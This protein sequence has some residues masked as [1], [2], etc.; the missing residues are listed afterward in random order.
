MPAIVCFSIVPLIHTCN[1]LLCTL[2]ELKAALIKAHHSCITLE[3]VLSVL[4][5]GQVP[6]DFRVDVKLF[7]ALCCLT[8]RMFDLYYLSV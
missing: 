5:L 2:Q 3:Q 8:E 7:A 6:S 1:H 4:E